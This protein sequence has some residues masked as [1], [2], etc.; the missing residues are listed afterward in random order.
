[1]KSLLIVLA[2]FASINIYSQ[3]EVDF[4]N[5]IGEKDLTNVGSYLA[6]SVTFSLDGNQKTLSKSK[7]VAELRGFLKDQ[8]IQKFKILHNGKSS[9]RASSYRVA[10]I[11]TKGETYRIFAYSEGTGA[12]SRVVEVRIDAM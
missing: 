4:L 2:T 10:R 12:N 11:K 1:M 3:T 6:P 7:A 9:D 8:N 5:A